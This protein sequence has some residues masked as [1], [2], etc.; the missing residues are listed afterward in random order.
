[1]SPLEDAVAYYDRALERAEHPLRGVG[2]ENPE[3]ERLFGI[4]FVPSPT[5]IQKLQE[6]RQVVVEI[7]SQETASP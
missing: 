2:I 4:R 6:L 1:M 7:L 5:R 3:I